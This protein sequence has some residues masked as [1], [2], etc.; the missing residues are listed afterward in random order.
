MESLIEVRPSKFGLGLFARTSIAEGTVVCNIT[1]H[2]EMDLEG[3][4]HLKEKESHALQIDFDRYLL[5]E[6]P[7]LYSNHSCT[8]N[9]AINGSMTL[10]TLRRI[11]QDEE[12]FWDYSTSMLERRWTMP[13]AC[14]TPA[15][16]NIVQD[17][18]LLPAH[19]RNRYL[20]QQLLLPFIAQFMEQQLARSA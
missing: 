19:V 20:E 18:D 14:G 1:S 5:C 3:T 9:C 10:F 7:F 11:E 8:P 2:R 17:F 12:L 15:C 4:I 6:P 16:R 13:C